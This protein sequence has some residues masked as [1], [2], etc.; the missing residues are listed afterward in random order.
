MTA[1]AKNSRNLSRTTTGSNNRIL[2]AAK[3]KMVSN[4]VAL[5]TA[6]QEVQEMDSSVIQE[7]AA[8]LLLGL[9]DKGDN[10]ED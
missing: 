10:K 8:A 4:P 7:T 6:N 5:E 1:P 3:N 9:T 2:T